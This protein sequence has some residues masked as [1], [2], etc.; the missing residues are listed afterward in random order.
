MQRNINRRIEVLVPIKNPTV[1]EQIMDQIIQANLKDNQQSWVLLSDGC[2]QRVRTED[3]PYNAHHF[4]MTNP[5]LSG[6][7]SAL[8]PE[9]YKSAKRKARRMGKTK[10][11]GKKAL[12]N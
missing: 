5:S 10:K 3:P 7:G 6:R 8:S 1:H 11:R 2:Y 4:F 9:R 12:R